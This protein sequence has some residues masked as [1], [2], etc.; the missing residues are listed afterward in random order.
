MQILNELNNSD[1]LNT[2]IAIHKNSKA[3]AKDIVKCDECLVGTNGL[4]KHCNKI[5]EKFATYKIYSDK[6]C[7]GKE[8][9]AVKNLAEKIPEEKIKKFLSCNVK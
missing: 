4:K 2:F 8:L 1:L 6:E 7:K 9:S 3:K 5:Y